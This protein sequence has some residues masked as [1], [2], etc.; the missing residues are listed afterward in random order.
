MS[1]Q[2]GNLPQ[3]PSTK[4]AAFKKGHSKFCDKYRLYYEELGLTGL[5]LEDAIAKVKE[6]PYARY[7]EEP[8][9][10]KEPLKHEQ[11]KRKTKLRKYIKKIKIDELQDDPQETVKRIE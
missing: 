10:G 8:I 7:K 9:E 4:T 1:S 3:H 11:I 2:N 6:R 5:K